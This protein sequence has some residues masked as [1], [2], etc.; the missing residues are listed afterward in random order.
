MKSENPCFQYVLWYPEFVPQMIG[1][2]QLFGAVI[3]KESVKQA[4]VAEA[5]VLVVDEAAPV[6]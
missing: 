5:P 1:D 4:P 6:S 2:P 3:A